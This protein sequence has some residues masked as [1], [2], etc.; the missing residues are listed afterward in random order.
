M[1]SETPA[2]KA[3]P[4]AVDIACCK[5]G[6]EG[7]VEGASAGQQKFQVMACYSGYPGGSP[8]QTSNPGPI[9]TVADDLAENWCHVIS[10]RQ[11]HHIVLPSLNAIFRVPTSVR[12]KSG[13]IISP[14]K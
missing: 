1:I 5:L 12:N 4:G 7:K 14:L 8:A 3:A 6:G 13:N 2:Q 10:N 9:I 11:A